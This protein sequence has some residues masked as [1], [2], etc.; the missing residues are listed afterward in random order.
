MHSMFKD[1][2][3]N[4]SLRATGPTLK[5]YFKIINRSASCG[6]KLDGQA[7]P[8]TEYE[9]IDVDKFPEKIASLCEAANRL[10]GRFSDFECEKEFKFEAQGSCHMSST[11]KSP[12]IKQHR[13]TPIFNSVIEDVNEYQEALHDTSRA[14]PSL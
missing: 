14:G 6:L 9:N 2:G 8:G 13:L 10:F 4:S 11:K 7:V 12:G 1:F 5:A 3:E